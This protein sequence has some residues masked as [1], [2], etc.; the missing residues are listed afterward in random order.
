MTIRIETDELGLDE[1]VM[2]KCTFHIERMS[3]TGFWIGI[4]NRADGLYH[5]NL[6]LEDGKLKARMEKAE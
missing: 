1:A 3:N 2:T 5:I 6:Y 4:D